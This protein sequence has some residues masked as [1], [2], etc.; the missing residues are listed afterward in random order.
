MSK[1]AIKVRVAGETL[2][3]SGWWFEEQRALRRLRAR[4]VRGRTIR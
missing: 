2:E 1:D 3:I 4:Q